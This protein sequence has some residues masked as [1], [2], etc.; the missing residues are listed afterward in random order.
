V[1]SGVRG[2]RYSLPAV[3]LMLLLISSGAAA[4]DRKEILGVWHGSSVCVDREAA[5][6]CR[7]EEVIYEFREMTPPVAGKLTVK[8]DKVVEGKVVPMGVLDVVRDPGN[9]TWSCD[10]Q[11]PR[12]HGLWSYTLRG[13]DELAGTLISIPDRALL[14]KAS[15]HRAPKT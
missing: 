3:C 10:F 7:D 6:A 15:A 2:A 5:P 4:E 1:N 9:E 13:K 12:F 11:T 14:R 8:A